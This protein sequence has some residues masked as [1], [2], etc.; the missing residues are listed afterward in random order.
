MNRRLA[1]EMPRL[2]V[3]NLGNSALLPALFALI[4]NLSSRHPSGPELIRGSLIYLN[5]SA[6][7]TR[8]VT[9]PLSPQS[10]DII[11][12]ADLD[13][14]GLV[15]QLAGGYNLLS[16]RP[17]KM[18]LLVGARFLKLD[19]DISVDLS[20]LGQN[21][22]FT[23]SE[24]GSVWDGFIGAKGMYAFNSRWSFPYYV[25]IGTGQS[26]LTWQAMAGVAY[27]AAKWVDIAL[28]YRYMEWEVGG[29]F[30]DDINFSGPTLGAV[31]R[32]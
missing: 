24:S 1:A 17:L 31:F 3:E 25:D 21:R 9:V 11:A 30:V 15:F 23:G 18:D 28:G 26:D 16:E 6:D 32:W 22:Q 27:H 29:N 10:V 19:S 12:H 7:D 2:C 5:V 4:R 14:A 20:A 8:K 13:L